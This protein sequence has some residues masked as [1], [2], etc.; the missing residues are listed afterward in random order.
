[1]SAVQCELCPKACLIGEGQ[2]GDCR[3]RANLG[4]KLRA[5]T[6]GHP[7]AVNLDPI[8]KK[9]LNHFLPGTRV[10]S[11]ATVGCNLHCKNCQNWEIS[12][13]DPEDSTAAALAPKEVAALAQRHQCPSV[14]YTYTE[15]IAYYEYAFDCAVAVRAAGLRNVWVTAGYINEAPLRELCRVLDAATIDLKAIRDA[16]YRDICGGTLQPVLNTLVVTKAL[17]VELEVSH[18]IIPTLNDSDQELT[19]L[20]RWVAANLGR[21]TPLHFLRF[22]PQYRLRHLPPTP[23]E[24]LTRAREIARAAGMHYVYLGNL[25]EDDAGTTRCPGCRRVLLQRRGHLV[26]E[27]RV[28]DG[29]CPDCQTGI[30]GVW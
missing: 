10:L 25:L 11:L 3:I 27:N 9:P 29:Q 23:A 22:V 19:E 6:Y 2:R 4:G 1:M 15:A 21:E 26:L 14:A 13:R 18:L 17:G 5:L 16:F 28:K 24:T 12:Q 30:Y 20:C 8:E 7:V